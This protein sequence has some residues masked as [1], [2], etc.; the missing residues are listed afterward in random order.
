[1]TSVYTLNYTHDII[2]KKRKEEDINLIKVLS[3]SET[4]YD[5]KYIFFYSHIIV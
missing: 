1:M 3:L 5:R 2:G 4:I